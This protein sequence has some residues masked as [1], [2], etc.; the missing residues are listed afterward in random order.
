[1]RILI[2][3][4]VLGLCSPVVEAAAR[5]EKCKVPTNDPE[6]LCPVGDA[7]LQAIGSK[8]CS[9]PNKV[10]G[11]PG[12]NGYLPGQKKEYQGK[13]YQCFPNGFMLA[14]GEE[15]KL[16]TSDKK[17]LCPPLSACRKAI[18]KLYCSSP[19]MACGWRDTEGYSIGEK[20]DWQ[21]KQYECFAN[22]FQQ[23]AAPPATPA[24][25]IALLKSQG[26][27]AVV[28]ATAVKEA[29]GT[30]GAQ[31]AQ[32]LKSAGLSAVAV[33]GALKAVF[34]ANEAKVAGWL[35][36][37]GWNVPTVSAVLDDNFNASLSLIASIMKA[38]G[39]SAR[40]IIQAMKAVEANLHEDRAAAE[41]KKLSGLSTAAVFDAIENE[42]TLEPVPAS[43]ALLAVGFPPDDV[44]AL[45]ELRNALTLTVAKEVLKVVHGNNKAN[46]G[47]ALAGFKRANL[48]RQAIEDVMLALRKWSRAEIKTLLDRAYG[49]VRK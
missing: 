45:L 20:R 21:S 42:M 36:G 40:V 17:F 16:G 41:L 29:F 24:A 9:N 30:S 37:A 2:L 1:M 25:L 22:G 34:Q 28:I 47:L 49:A 33:G 46:I 31:M 15:C 27:S 43:M 39:M 32:H 19:D 6:F 18:S 44:V 10:C 3:I 23:V 14:L 38:E 26:Q 8:Y 35:L 13:T 12:K 7:C 48:Q 4:V 11:W 5:G